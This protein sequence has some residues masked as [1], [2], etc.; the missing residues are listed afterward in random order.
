MSAGTLINCAIYPDKFYVTC[1]VVLLNSATKRTG[2]PVAKS[3]RESYQVVLVARIETII[4][5]T[6]VALV[7]C[8]SAKG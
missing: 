1:W 7:K 4:L 2:S 5:R 3:R 6:L 8:L